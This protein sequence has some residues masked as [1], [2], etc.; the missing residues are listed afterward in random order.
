MI[1]KGTNSRQY[2]THNWRGFDVTSLRTMKHEASSVI[3]HPIANWRPKM[4]PRIRN[5]KNRIAAQ[6][7]ITAIFPPRMRGAVWLQ[8]I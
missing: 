7:S 8:I 4:T 6:A 1:E 5:S 2:L 3:I